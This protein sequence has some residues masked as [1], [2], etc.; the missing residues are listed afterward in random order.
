[1]SATVADNVA[2]GDSAPDPTLIE[3]SLE[4]ACAEEISPGLELG[5]Q[6]AGLSGGQ[7]QRVAVARAFYRHLRGAA[8]VIALDEPSAALDAQTEARLWASVR[9]LADAGAAVLLVSHRES[10][11]RIADEVVGLIPSEVIA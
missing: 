1:M 3:R 11:R 5:V 7:A 2:L 9:A 4:L 8:P 10:A 6:G